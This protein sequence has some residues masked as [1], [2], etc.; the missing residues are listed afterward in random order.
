M[1]GVSQVQ[2]VTVGLED[3][4]DGEYISHAISE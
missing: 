2:P 4:I 3:L 1:E